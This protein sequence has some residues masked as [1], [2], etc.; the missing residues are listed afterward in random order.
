MNIET[1]L[2]GLCESQDRCAYIRG[3]LS[4]LDIPYKLVEYGKNADGEALRQNIVIDWGC[5]ISDYQHI[6]SAHYDAV[7][8]SP[9]AND[10]AA[11]VLSLTHL[12]ETINREPDRP[13]VAIVFFDAEEPSHRYANDV[14]C[15]GS[16]LFANSM[17]EA[18]CNPALFLVL[19]V[20]GFGGTLFYDSPFE[21]S[22]MVGKLCALYPK[23]FKVTTPTSD[24]HIMSR[25]GVESVLL[26]ALPDDEIEGH[27]KT[28][29]LLHSKYDSPETVDLQNI[30][31]ISS[32]L[33]TLSRKI[34][35]N[36]IGMILERKESDTVKRNDFLKTV[37]DKELD[38]VMY[39]G[40]YRNS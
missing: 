9:G 11:G 39:Y 35:E 5:P 16:Y 21:D 38:S 8:G 30:P 4:G 6:Y 32:I 19:D 22:D 29:S 20:V 15:P 28:W 31:W 2:N 3:M 24:E 18:G 33:Y 34:T 26:G 40:L 13:K 7:E 23:I 37:D 27:R 36:G 12:A 14:Y 17:L 25:L 1:N 10:N